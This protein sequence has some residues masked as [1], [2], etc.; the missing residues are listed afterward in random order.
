MRN[1]IST[2][3]ISLGVA[4][5]AGG[6]GNIDGLVGENS[7]AFMALNGGVYLGV[8]PAPS[9]LHAGGYTF[10]ARYYSYDN[11]CPRCA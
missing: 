9:G 1:L 4:V 8:R 3:G 2:L 5:L 11:S 7:A 6:C 10:A